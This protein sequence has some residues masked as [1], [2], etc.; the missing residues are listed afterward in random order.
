MKVRVS[1]PR[2]NLHEHDDAVEGL[3]RA[4]AHAPP[5]TPPS[6]PADGTCWGDDKRYVLE[7]RLGRGGMG[8][9]YLAR[10]SLLGRLVALK[11]L[12]PGE[13]ADEA[14][15]RARLLREARLAARLEHERI[16]RVYDVQEHEGGTFVAMEYVRGSTLRAWMSEPRSAGEILRVAMQIAEGLAVLHSNGI[17]HRDLKPENAMLTAGGGIKLV[18]FGLAGDIALAPESARA[19]VA[20]MET[21]S[22]GFGGTPGYMAPEHYSHGRVDARA[23]VFAL[24]VVIYELVTG[25]RPFKGSMML[26]AMLDEVSALDEPVWERFPE[27]LR[28]V[29]RRALQRDP[30]DRFAHGTAFL[31]ALR[32]VVADASKPR[33]SD[34]ELGSLADKVTRFWLDNV[35][36]RSEIAGVLEQPRTIDLSFVA[37]SWART[38]RAV[39]GT[40]DE[41]ID[42]SAPVPQIF[43]AAGR[44]LLI[45]GDPGCGKTLSLLLIVRH[46][47]QRQEAEAPVPVVFNLSTWRRGNSIVHWLIEEL[48]NI[49]QV[50]RHTARRW[51]ESNRL[52]LLLDGLDEV[53]ALV[54]AEC[55]AAIGEFVAQARPP[56]LVVTSRVEACAAIDAR[57]ALNAAVVLHPL[58]REQVT[59][60]VGSREQVARDRLQTVVT[61][62]E[63]ITEMVRTPLILNLVTRICGSERSDAWID[64]GAERSNDL[65][66]RICAMY[67]SEIAGRRPASEKVRLPAVERHASWL[68]SAMKADN[69]SVFRVEDIQPS[70]LR[71]RRA[72]MA[73]A[74]V[75]R[76]IVASVL[77]AATILPTARTPLRNAGFQATLAFAWD[78]ALAGTVSFTVV[79]GALALL[80]LLRPDTLARAALRGRAHERVRA[81]A[82][83]LLSGAV[84]AVMLRGY[85]HAIVEICSFEY[86]LLASIPLAFA[87]PTDGRDIRMHDRL[88]WSLAAVAQR[89][90]ALLGAVVA[91]VLWFWILEGFRVAVL[92]GLVVGLGGLVVAGVRADRMPA[93][94]RANSGILSAMG[95]GLRAAIYAFVVTT[96]AFGSLYGVAYGLAVAL[97][98]STLAF[99]R[100]GGL[101]AVYHYVLRIALSLERAIGLNLV[102]Q[103]DAAAEAGLLRKLGGSYLF[104]HSLLLDYYA[105]RTSW[106]RS[107][108]VSR[109]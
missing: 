75:S 72:K 89:R 6:D 91:M 11:V 58:T 47:L 33:W 17:V 74:M 34:P 43:E 61:A 105:E 42:A 62:D 104:M 98:L 96:A 12:D 2:A 106:P 22:F 54:R 87:R 93:E 100:F 95:S 68:A 31:E 21:S 5:R 94:D 40:T 41:P 27:S 64:E 14:A 53:A 66:V 46:L 15:H 77:C 108:A 50:P 30:N 20:G 65:A 32:D 38:F 101:D 1:D 86:A 107:I 28:R 81:L 18:D 69:R 19:A 71:T 56:G 63:R 92:G 80:D 9:V 52:L 60:F 109:I 76:F 79:Y 73:Y 70:W 57:L 26:R 85:H 45:L 16:A 82:V 10:D 23:D 84:I 88:Y 103:L 35:L 13:A 3:V 29:T 8:T 99:L 90:W 24:G 39:H 67:V 59:S 102:R 37:G 48:G 4:I 55:V 97:T 49:Y 36:G 7:R 83:A 51:L 78:L 25:D 44:M